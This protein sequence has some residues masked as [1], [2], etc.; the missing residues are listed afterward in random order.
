MF[1]G[2]VDDIIEYH[3]EREEY[4]DSIRGALQY[5]FGA[6]ERKG[7]MTEEENASFNEWLVFDFVLPNGK[8]LIE[9]YLEKNADRMTGE[10]GYACRD[11]LDNTYSLFKVVNVIKDVGLTLRDAIFD[12]EYSVR[13]KKGSAQLHKNDAIFCRVGRVGDHWEIMSGEVH[14][15]PF[16]INKELSQMFKDVKE[17]IGMKYLYD[18]FI[19]E[20]HGEQEIPR[21][22]EKEDAKEVVKRMEKFLAKHGLDTFVTIPLIQRWIYEFGTKD[23]VFKDSNNLTA[24]FYGLMN[25]E[26]KK[27][28]EEMFKAVTDLC[29]SS[30]M[31]K[32]NGMSPNEKVAVGKHVPRFA[33]S[34]TQ[35]FTQGFEYF[36]DAMGVMNKK[37]YKKAEEM[38]K[39]GFKIV[40]KDRYIFPD[41]YRMFCNLAVCCLAQNLIVEG[42]KFLSFVIELN[43]NYGFGQKVFAGHREYIADWTKEDKKTLE[44][45]RKDLRDYIAEHPATK[46]YEFLKKTGVNFATPVATVDKVFT[47]GNE[48][49]HPKMGRNDICNCGS[50]LKYKKCHG[51]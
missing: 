7:T 36:V 33:I 48:E 29:N 4:S 2:L 5:F 50:G 49:N 20:K 14:I 9:N 40:L 11:M 19:K 24:A 46:Y 37:E 41:P 30:P 15:F 26:S 28:T 6:K 17:P 18:H 32:L 21:A 3:A 22:M 23:A 47:F 51:R 45:M 13:E 10:K 1:T 39:K 34:K 35:L 31:E 12:K 44:R 43:P 16:V 38:H 27:D 8:N 25:S 42:E